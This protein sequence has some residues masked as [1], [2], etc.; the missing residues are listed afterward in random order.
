METIIF[1]HK[2][3][4]WYLPYALRQCVKSNPSARVIL[5]GDDTNEKYSNII[6]HKNYKDYCSDAN[7]FSKLYLHYST[8]PY[9]YELFC[10][11]RWFIWLKFMVENDINIALLP[12]TDVLILHDI[13]QYFN[14]SQKKINFTKGESNYM[15]FMYMH[16]T[17]LIDICRFIVN[18]Y[19]MEPQTK[20]LQSAY[21][22]YLKT[23]T[24]GGI[25][26]ITLF[27]YYEQQQPLTIINTELEPLNNIIFI[28]SMQSKLFACDS[29]KNVQI[30]KRKGVY[31]AKRKGEIYTVGGMHCF[32]SQKIL[33]LKYYTGVNA[34]KARLIYYWKIS[35]IHQLIIFI[36]Q[37]IL[38]EKKSQ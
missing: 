30:L 9:D 3:D 19:K 1:L 8:N 20:F 24:H 32:G 7:N 34:W 11:Q 22:D 25:S 29:K 10:I 33:L 27:S 2:G 26:D 35:Y 38:K 14:Y 18:V 21:E 17:T 16:R 37:G 23:E 12:D 36:R 5:L 13:S 31:Y 28:H 6:E 4:S 15:G